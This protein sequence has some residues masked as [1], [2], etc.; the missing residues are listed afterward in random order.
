MLGG[1]GED[2]LAFLL[3]RDTLVAGLHTGFERDTV[4]RG[5]GCV[6]PG[7]TQGA[8]AELQD[9]VVAEDV[10]QRGHV[11]DVDTAGGHREGAGH[12]APVLIEEDAAR[13]VFLHVGLTQQVDPADGRLTVALELADDRAGVQMIAAG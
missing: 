13:A 4:G 7:V 6:A 1:V 8:A 12:G 2:L 5:A 11:P 9:G 3:D 10:H